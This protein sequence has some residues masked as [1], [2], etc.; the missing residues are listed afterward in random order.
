ML[1]FHNN[2]ISV[3]VLVI[4]LLIFKLKPNVFIHLSGV[5]C[6]CEPSIIPC[7]YLSVIVCTTL[8]PRNCFQSVDG[9]NAIPNTDDVKLVLVVNNELKM[10]KGKIGA[11]V[12]SLP[13]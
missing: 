10:G 8:L 11:Q 1:L 3:V 6:I 7:Y 5:F 9:S 2:Y 13:P 4:N 12:R